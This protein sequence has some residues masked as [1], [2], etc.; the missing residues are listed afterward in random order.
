M[1]KIKLEIGRA[2]SDAI[3]REARA[4]GMKAADL[5]AGY[6]MLGCLVDEYADGGG[7]V[8]IRDARGH[9]G[10]EV[11]VPARLMTRPTKG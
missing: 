11:V 8:T 2:L 7:E 4:R 9:R 3:E 5:V 6:I 10:G 1:A